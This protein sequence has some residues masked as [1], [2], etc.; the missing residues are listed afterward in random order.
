MK[1]VR[2]ILSSKP[3]NVWS[4][5]PSSSVYE[6]LQLMADKDIGAVLVVEN[7]QVVGIFS[8]RDYAR[9]VVLKGKSS[10]DTPVDELMTKDVLFV[11]PQQ[12]LDECMAVMTDKHIRHLPVM[13]KD[14]LIGMITIGDLVKAIISDQQF[15]IQELENYISGAR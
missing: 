2:D 14:Q 15:I 3:R 10:K 12:S 7:G 11:R 6:A 1:S 13:E 8:E 5:S 4:V 9:K